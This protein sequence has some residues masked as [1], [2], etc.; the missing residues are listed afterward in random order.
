[1]N[2]S[3]EQRQEQARAASYVSTYLKENYEWES[4]IKILATV[5]MNELWSTDD[6]RFKVDVRKLVDEW[7]IKWETTTEAMKQVP[8]N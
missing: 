4:I 8:T 3:L 2:L 7:I 6:Q 1:M 5:L